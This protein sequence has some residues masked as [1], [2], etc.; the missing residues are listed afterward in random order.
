MELVWPEQINVLAG[1]GGGGL[2]KGYSKLKR[3]YHLVEFILAAGYFSK[4]DN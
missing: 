3:V 4:T 1:G 2:H